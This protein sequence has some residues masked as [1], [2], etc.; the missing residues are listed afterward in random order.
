M[1]GMT[2]ARSV[3]YLVVNSGDMTVELRAANW[4]ANLVVK[5]AADSVGNSAD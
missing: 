1:V 4:A 3:G 2:A 5:K